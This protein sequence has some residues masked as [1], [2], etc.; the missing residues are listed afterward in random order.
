MKPRFLADA[1]L[2]RRI[3]A[4]L[5]R[6]EPSIDFQDA[7]AGNV[8]GIR[9]PEVLTLAAEAGRVLVSH[10]RRTM[11]KHF[12]RFIRRQN[13]P[14]LIIVSQDLDIGRAIEELL[15]IWMATD[16][17]EWENVAVFLPL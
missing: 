10:D 4:G 6:R 14:G 2:N 15:L 5:R 12:A 9:D 7:Q 16:A 17:V 11:L 8:I 1:D 13:S 3:V